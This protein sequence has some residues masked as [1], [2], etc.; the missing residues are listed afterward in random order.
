MKDK[1]NEV[2]NEIDDVEAKIRHLNNE[3]TLF[4]RKEK[5]ERIILLSELLVPTEDKSFIDIKIAK[6]ICELNHEFERVFK[7][8]DTLAYINKHVISEYIKE[9]RS[10]EE[11]LN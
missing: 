11:I 3:L 2:F 4:S 1:L 7:F 8:G 5:L 9:F 6:S 10:L